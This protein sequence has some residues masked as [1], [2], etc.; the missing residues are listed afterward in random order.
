MNRNSVGQKDRQQKYFDQ[1]EDEEFEITR[2]HGSGRLYTFLMKQKFSRALQALPFG[3]SGIKVLN[4]CCGSGMD[5]EFLTQRGAKVTV[6]D[7]SHGA[8][9]RTLERGKRFGF[10][11]LSTVG[12]AEHL[13]FPDESFDMVFVHDGL[14]HLPLP[15]S[16]I[17]EMARVSRRAVLITEPANAA[18]T[19]LAVKLGLAEVYEEAGNYVYRFTKKELQSLFAREKM[20]MLTFQR[21]L[22]YYHHQPKKYYKVFDNPIMLALAKLLFHSSNFLFGR[23][24]N[25]LCCVGVKEL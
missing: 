13:P 2:P 15:Q 1:I 24:G 10:R 16:G 7:I 9:Q 18:V 4:I 20:E 11:V 5:A 14:H 6:L 8:I 3:I 17:R 23:F 19:N 25:K 22:M 21:Y 12:D